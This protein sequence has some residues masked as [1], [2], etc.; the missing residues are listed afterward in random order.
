MISGTGKI[1]IAA[2]E[3]VGGATLLATETLRC[4]F[5]G[6]SPRRPRWLAEQMVQIGIHSLLVSGIIIFLIGMVIAFQ[7]AYQ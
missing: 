2:F 7:T 6:R 4:V 1:F 3:T 5:F